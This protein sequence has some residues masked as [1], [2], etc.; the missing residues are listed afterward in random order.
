MREWFQNEN[1]SGLDR[2]DF[3]LYPWHSKKFYKNNLRLDASLVQKFILEPVVE[4]EAPLIFA[5]NAWWWENLEN[6]GVEVISRLGDGGDRPL[7]HGDKAGAKRGVMVAKL[8]HGGLIIAE[9]HIGSAAP[10][11][12]EKVQDFKRQV[13]EN[14]A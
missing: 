1:L 10:P 5:F 13:L 11:A 2:V 9:K 3:E 7:D 12:R 8:P 4:L 6:L 14:L